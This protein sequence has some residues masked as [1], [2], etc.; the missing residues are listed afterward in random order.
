MKMTQNSISTPLYV[1]KIPN[2]LHFKSN[3]LRAF[4]EYQKCAQIPL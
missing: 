4:Q 2:D 3:L 1:L